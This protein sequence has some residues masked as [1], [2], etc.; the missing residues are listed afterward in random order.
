MKRGNLGVFCSLVSTILLT[1]GCDVIEGM[2]ARRSSDSHESQAES[3]GSAAPRDGA[4][5]VDDTGTWRL[6]PP[7][8]LQQR[9]G[10]QVSTTDRATVGA[11]SPRP[12]NN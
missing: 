10:A 8:D 9:E 6:P 11:K 2:F 5:V 12:G 7:N 1:T 4:L 3:G